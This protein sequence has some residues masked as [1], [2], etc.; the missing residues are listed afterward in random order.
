MIYFGKEIKGG[1]LLIGKIKQNY[2]P[3]TYYIIKGTVSYRTVLWI[4]QIYPKRNNPRR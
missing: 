3:W 2:R 4:F 1:I